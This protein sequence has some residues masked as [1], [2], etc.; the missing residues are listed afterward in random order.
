MG[1]AQEGSAGGC[2]LTAPLVGAGAQN[3]NPISSGSWVGGQEE[4]GV[5]GASLTSSCVGGS[6]AV[7]GDSSPQLYTKSSRA[8]PTALCQSAFLT[9]TV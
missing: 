9:L 2:V 4:Y 5:V 6:G 3:S 8:R 7:S 1:S